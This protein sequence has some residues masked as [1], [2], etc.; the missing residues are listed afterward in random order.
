MS[1]KVPKMSMPATVGNGQL[2]STTDL[3]SGAPQSGSN[4]PPYGTWPRGKTNGFFV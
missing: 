4:K 1:T 2:E 3:S